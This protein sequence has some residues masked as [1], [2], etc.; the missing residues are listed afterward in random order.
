M[1][2]LKKPRKGRLHWKQ[3]GRSETVCVQTCRATQR[4][5]WCT[6]SHSDLWQPQQLRRAAKHKQQAA[7]PCGECGRNAGAER[8]KGGGER[9]SRRQTLSYPLR[10]LPFLHPP[11]TSPFR[12]SDTCP[13][14]LTGTLCAPPPPSPPPHVQRSHW[15]SDGEQRGADWPLAPTGANEKKNQK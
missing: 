11:S 1:A 12:G 3:T 5:S 15:L 2:V 9:G 7:A 8:E 4:H 10:I 14:H 6:S 13:S